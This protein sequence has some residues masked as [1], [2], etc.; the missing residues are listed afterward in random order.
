VNYHNVKVKL[1]TQLVFG[2]RENKLQLGVPFTNL[3]CLVSKSKIF[4]GSN[5]HSELL[6]GVKLTFSNLR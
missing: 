6:S 4:R 3:N 5:G 1:Q 2:E